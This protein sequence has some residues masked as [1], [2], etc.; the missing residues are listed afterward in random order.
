MWPHLAEFRKI[1]RLFFT[2]L[3]TFQDPSTEQSL[4]FFFSSFCSCCSSH[5]TLEF[6]LFLGRNF[7][8]PLEKF[9]SDPV[10]THTVTGFA[11]VIMLHA[12]GDSGSA[13]VIVKPLPSSGQEDYVLLAVHSQTITCKQAIMS[14]AWLI[15]VTVVLSLNPL[16]GFFSSCCCAMWEVTARPN[17]S[18]VLLRD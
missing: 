10:A 16:G 7:L 18:T 9:Q 14:L 4:D 15:V 12:Q 11:H 1:V 5:S 17:Q 8:R 2:F 13:F 3:A 6:N